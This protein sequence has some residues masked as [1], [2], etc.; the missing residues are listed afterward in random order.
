MLLEAQRDASRGLEMSAFLLSFA[1]A[2]FWSKAGYW[3]LALGLGG[4]LVVLFIPARKHLLE[5]SLAGLF[6]LMILA[7]VVVGHVGDDAILAAV[8]TR[9]NNA[10]SSLAKIAAPRS[11]TDAQ[12]AKIAEKLKPFANQEWGAAMYWDS[13]VRGHSST[14]I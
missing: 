11:L 7:G 3:L 10:E 2:E 4:D 14:H 5:K 12:I 6:T 13:K 1:S 8:E 9:A